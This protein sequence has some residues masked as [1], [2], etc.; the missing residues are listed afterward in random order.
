VSLPPLRLDQTLVAQHLKAATEIARRLSR[1]SPGADPKAAAFIASL[2]RLHVAVAAAHYD[3]QLFPRPGIANPEEA[4][5]APLGVSSPL[6][7]VTD[8]TNGRK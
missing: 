3:A 4:T 2:R 1:I 8:I 6:P 7:P 5:G